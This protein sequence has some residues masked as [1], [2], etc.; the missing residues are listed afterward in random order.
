[1]KKFKQ[2]FNEKNI[3]GLVETIFID[4]VGEVD[5]KVDSGNGAYNVLHGDSIEINEGICKFRTINH[6]IIEKPVV[7]MITINVGAGNF[8]ERPIVEFNLKFGGVEFQNVRFSIGDRTN[9]EYPVLIGKE[10]IKNEL[11]A[12][13][14]VS[15]VNL[16]AKGIEVDY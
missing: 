4:G 1:M 8:E 6:K 2:F 15:G 10:F 13:I 11:D 3:V 12:L 9:N 5:A 14:D 16:F 7:D